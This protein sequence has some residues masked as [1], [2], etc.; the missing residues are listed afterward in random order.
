M[1]TLDN[2][3]IT[4]APIGFHVPEESRFE[5]K[6]KE[7]LIKC[8]KKKTTLPEIRK[9]NFFA[10]FFK[11]RTLDSFIEMLSA[12]NIYVYIMVERKFYEGF[13]GANYDEVQMQAS[14]V[15]SNRELDLEAGKLPREFEYALEN[16]KWRDFICANLEVCG[17]TDESVEFYINAD[18]M[19][20]EKWR[21]VYHKNKIVQEKIDEEKN[22]EKD[23]VELNKN[24]LFLLKAIPVISVYL[25]FSIYIAGGFGLFLFVIAVFTVPVFC[26]VMWSVYFKL[27]GDIDEYKEQGAVKNRFDTSPAPIPGYIIGGIVFA[28]MFAIAWSPIFDSARVSTKVD[29]R[30]KQL[31]DFFRWAA[32]Q[33][34]DRC[35]IIKSSSC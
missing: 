24:R 34:Y 7:H 20:W 14:F 9:S 5:V 26:G 29:D 12:F 4:I 18:K 10:N 21:E 32:N 23:K 16:S 15:F 3:I 35:Q 30:S 11:K 8:G 27:S 19:A 2:L 17:A 13:S 28:F 6:I 31:E 25:I 33:K 1:E 22:F